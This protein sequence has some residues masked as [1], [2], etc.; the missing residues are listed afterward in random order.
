MTKFIEHI[1]DDGTIEYVAENIEELK[2]L[3][4]EA[5]AKRVKIELTEEQLAETILY[6]Q[7]HEAR[8]YLKSTDWYA[9]RL[10]ETGKEIPETVLEKRAAARLLLST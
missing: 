1:R 3:S 10:A 2:A 5:E 7:K 4:A 9:H 8:E 6:Q